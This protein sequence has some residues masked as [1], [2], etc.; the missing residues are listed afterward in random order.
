MF[1]GPGKRLLYRATA[2]RFTGKARWRLGMPSV[3]E[4]WA[5]Y[6]RRV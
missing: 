6:G 3:S 5:R 2:G 4:L 1:R